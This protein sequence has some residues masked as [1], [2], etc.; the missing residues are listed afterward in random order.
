LFISISRV[1]YHKSITKQIKAP[2]KWWLKNW[3][4]QGSES[5]EGF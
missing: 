2:S 3:E 4:K 5:E 1:E